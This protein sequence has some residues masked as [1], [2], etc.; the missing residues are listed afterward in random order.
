MLAGGGRGQL[1]TVY[2][3]EVLMGEHQSS[4]AFLSPT[5]ADAQVFFRANHDLKHSFPVISPAFFV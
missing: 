3:P 1:G 4:H 2:I 5:C